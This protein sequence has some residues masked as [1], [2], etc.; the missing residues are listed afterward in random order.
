[1]AGHP[2]DDDVEERSDRQA[3]EAHRPIRTP[4]GGTDLLAGACHGGE[5]YL[6]PGRR[7]GGGAG[8]P[9]AQS[10]VIPAIFDA[11]SMEHMQLRDMVQ[12]SC[13]ATAVRARS[14]TARVRCP[15]DALGRPECRAAASMVTGHRQPDSRAEGPGRESNPV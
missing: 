2:V 9:P 1:M 15:L 12:P 11:S 13:D 14:I 6:L 10:G 3:E 5:R 7:W 4:S 8:T